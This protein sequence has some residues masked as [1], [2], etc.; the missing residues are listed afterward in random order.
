MQEV[1]KVTEH[2][3]SIGHEGYMYHLTVHR[4]WGTYT[5]LEEGN[6]F[7]IKRIT[8]KPGASLSL[9]SHEHRSE[10]WVIVNGT[11]KIVN[12]DEEII[13]NTNEGAFVKAGNKHRLSNPGKVE[14]VM[15]ETQ[16]GGYLGEDDI[17]RYDDHYG[18][19]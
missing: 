17:V 10:H 12:G 9:Q 8:V 19:K 4:P 18:R 5:I 3:K 7:K 16:V 11:A 2:L 1:K 13:L 15:I 6:G 14:L